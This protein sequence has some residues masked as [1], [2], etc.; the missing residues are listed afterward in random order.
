MRGVHTNNGP[1]AADLLLPASGVNTPRL[2]KMVEVN[3]SLKESAGLLA[4]TTP[5]PR[6]PVMSLA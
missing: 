1:I 5:Q 6:L 4:P 3:V 2:A